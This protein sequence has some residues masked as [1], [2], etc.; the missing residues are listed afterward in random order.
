M[1]EGNDLVNDELEDFVLVTILV[2]GN[3]INVPG[4]NLTKVL[5]KLK[6]R[7]NRITESICNIPE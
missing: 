7:V 6:S 1:A 5:G 2:K 4:I 3:T